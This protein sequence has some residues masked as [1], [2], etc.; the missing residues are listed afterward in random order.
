MTAR[1]VK[2]WLA[3]VGTKPLFIEP[4][5]RGRPSATVCLKQRSSADWQI[6]ENR[7][8][9]KATWTYSALLVQVLV[10]N[11]YRQVFEMHS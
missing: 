10:K 11:Y 6:A 1:R 4:G 8:D 9:L 5:V 2:Q 7:T 3:S